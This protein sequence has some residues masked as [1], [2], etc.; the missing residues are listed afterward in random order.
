[1]MEIY[2]RKFQEEDIPYKVRWI[3][4]EKNNKFLHY[5]LPL[6][7]DKTLIWY[8]NVIYKKDR[9]DFTII[10]RHEPVGLIG[11]LNIDS[12]NKKAEF[13]VCLGEEKYKGRGIS[14]VAADQL[15]RVGYEQFGLKKIYLFTEVGNVWAQKLF[16]KIGF[17]KEG[18]LRNDLIYK[19]RSVDRYVY[20]IDVENYIYNY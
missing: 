7:E 14:A 18:L 12:K 1:M 2:I 6:S 16:E 15:I 20:G 17:E 8:R 5:D 4:D 9:I 11:L 10:Y 13:Y 19:E 3:N